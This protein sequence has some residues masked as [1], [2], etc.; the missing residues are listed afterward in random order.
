MKSSTY[1]CPISR[2]RTA[3]GELLNLSSSCKGLTIVAETLT[4]INEADEV[5]E[6]IFR[7]A[8]RQAL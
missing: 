5:I 7:K 6:E 3:D 8:S 4:E 2:T 1:S